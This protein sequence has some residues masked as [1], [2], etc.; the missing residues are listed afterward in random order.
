MFPLFFSVQRT[1]DGHGEGKECNFPSSIQQ[2]VI[3]GAIKEIL[4]WS[5][6]IFVCDL[7]LMRVSHLLSEEEP[8][9]DINISQKS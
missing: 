6:L 2:K 3:S 8:Q 4:L 1:A 5:F 9:D 7:K